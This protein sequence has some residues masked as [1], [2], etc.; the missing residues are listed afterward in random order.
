MKKLLFLICVIVI[1]GTQPADCQNA[2]DPSTRPAL[3]AGIVVDLMRAD[4]ISRFWNRFGE[5]GFKRLVNDGFHCRNTHYNYAP[6]YTAPGH[7]SIYTGSTP[8]GH[9]I[10]ANDWYSRTQG[11]MVYCVQDDTVRTIGS[12]SLNGKMSPANLLATTITDELQLA[13][14]GKSKIIGISIKDRGSIL[15]AGRTADAAYWFDISTGNWIS[16][17]WYMDSLPQWVNEFNE[18][19]WPDEYLSKPWNTLYPIH[20]YQYADNDQNRYEQ[21]FRDTSV[22]FP[23]DI[24][25]L[26]GGE[27]SLLR[28]IPAG[29]TFTKDMALAALANEKMGKDSVTDFLCLSFSTTDYLGHQF[30]TAS[31]E[32]EDCYLRLDRDIADL[33]QYLD[34]HCGK[35]KYLV[36]LTADHAS[37]HNPL[38][39]NDQKLTGGV[40]DIQIID[41]EIKKFLETKYGQP[42]WLVKLYNDQIY[43][44][45][46]KIFNSKTDFCEVQRAVAE[47]CMSKFDYIKTAVAACEFHT[48]D[49]NHPY[50][51]MMELGYCKGRSGDVMYQF[52]PEYTNTLYG[53]GYQGTDHGSVYNYDTHVP[54][55]WYGKNIPKGNTVRKIS[56]TDIAPTLSFLLNIPLPDAATGNPVLEIFSK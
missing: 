37:M 45:R 49:F 52:N 43:L 56:I 31:V 54:L 42:S 46:E 21:P 22:K 14:Q 12:N 30:G 25:G 48:G 33:L 39:L 13:T 41:A 11:K 53:N 29:N 3:V 5:N 34:Q 10:A 44:D 15:P 32:I 38:F 2:S 51:M 9:G 35:N 26:G 7:A 36:F 17:S 47:F 27:Y 18:R 1:A 8:E 6:T 28:K 23:H 4:Y 55:I 20:T 19:K 16:S 24:S 40:V 50:E